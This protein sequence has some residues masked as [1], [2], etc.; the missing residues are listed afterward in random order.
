MLQINGLFK[1]YKTGEGVVTAIQ[2]LNLTVQ[3]GE[4]VCLVGPSGCGKSTLLNIVADLD[5]PS[6][7]ETIKE[8]KCGL[9][10]QDP[11]L[12][13]WLKVKDNVAFGLKMTGMDKEEINKKVD[14]YLDLVRLKEFKNAYPHELSGGMKQRIALIR[15]LIMEPEILL[16]D[17]PFGS[18]DAQTREDLY[19]ILQNIWL[20]NKKTVLFVTHNVREAVCLGDR[21]VVMTARPGKIKKEFIITL[22]RPR[23]LSDMEVIKM[24]NIIKEELRNEIQQ[25]IKE[26]EHYEKKII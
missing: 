2:D 1:E 19:A 26:T 24:S 23:E 12:F 15:M 9:M 14:Y 13:P 4:F 7:G 18:L 21:V 10:F 3:K 8:K 25:V 5:T 6:K 17:E 16:M 11:T 22:P 20:K